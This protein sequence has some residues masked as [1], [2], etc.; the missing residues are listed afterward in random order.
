MELRKGFPV[1]HAIK[2]DFETAPE[3]TRGIGEFLSG[4]HSDYCHSLDF[5]VKENNY[6]IPKAQKE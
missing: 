4:Y 2:K 5:H 6:D 1:T 3:V